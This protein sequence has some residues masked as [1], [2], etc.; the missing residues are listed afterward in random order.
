[1]RNNEFRRQR[2]LL[3]TKPSL[4][5]NLPDTHGTTATSANLRAGTGVHLQQTKE[6]IGP[7]EEMFAALGKSPNGRT[8]IPTKFY[9][10]ENR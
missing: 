4:F 5:T 8:Q 6:H 3:G 1:M 2:G 7:L 9:H 10:E